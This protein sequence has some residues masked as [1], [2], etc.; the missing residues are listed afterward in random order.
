MQASTSEKIAM[1]LN[2]AGAESSGRIAPGTAG[3]PQ[4][5][6]N[7]HSGFSSAEHEVQTG[8]A[9]WYWP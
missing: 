2:G 1:M 9:K 7:F 5:M 6:Q 8:I 3:A 4:W